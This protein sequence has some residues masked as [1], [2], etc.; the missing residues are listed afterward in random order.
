MRVII[1]VLAALSLSS[2]GTTTQPDSFD[3]ALSAA[4]IQA[5]TPSQEVEQ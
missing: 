4:M 3:L 5:L 2:C 1:C